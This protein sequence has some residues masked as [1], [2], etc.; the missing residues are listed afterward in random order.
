MPC[1]T[2]QTT[3]IKFGKETNPDLLNA[4]LKELG[5]H[6]NIKFDQRTGELIIKSR[7]GATADLDQIKREYSRQVLIS[8][9]SQFGWNVE[10]STG[11]EFQHVRV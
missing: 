2:I 11:E 3:K 6:N 8:Q 1:D 5:L 9:A 7:Y 4:A 10:E